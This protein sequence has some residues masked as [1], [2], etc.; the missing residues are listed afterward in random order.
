[1]YVVEAVHSFHCHDGLSDVEPALLFREYVLFHQKSHQI[2]ALQELHDK[3]QVLLILEGALE[4]NDP[5]VLGESQDISLSPH[6]R[7]LV[8][9]DHLG[10]FHLLNGDNLLGLL[11]SADAHLSE[12][13]TPD[14]LQGLEVTDSD[15]CARETEQFCLLVLYLLLNQLLLLS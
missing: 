10:L 2:P 12:G 15:L 8:L 1:M 7:H 6:M 4:L 5:I 3:I 14:D 13:T 9:V 11:V